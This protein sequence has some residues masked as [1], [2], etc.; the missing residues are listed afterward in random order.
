M[1]IDSLDNKDEPIV[2]KN[3]M[4]LKFD[5]DVVYFI[6]V[7]GDEAWKHNPFSA[8]AR[9]YPVENALLHQ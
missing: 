9:L 1:T 5:D 8:A 3:D 7:L 4:R 2:I 6:P